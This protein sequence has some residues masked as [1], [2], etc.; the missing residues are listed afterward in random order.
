MI[1][2]L[3]FPP[4]F[5]ILEVGWDYVLDIRLDEDNVQAVEVYCLIIGR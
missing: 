2:T 5:R 4:R 1:G 3:R